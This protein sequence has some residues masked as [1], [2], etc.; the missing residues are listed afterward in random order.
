MKATELLHAGRLSDALAA[1]LDDVKKRPTD[2]AARF[3]LAE[4]LSLAGQWERADKQLETIANQAPDALLGVSLFRQLLRGELARHECFT[5]GRA[6]EL[7]TEPTAAIKLHLQALVELRAGNEALAAQLLN[8][9]DEARPAVAGELDGT[10]FDTLR[11]LDDLT[12][13]FF[14]V[15]TSTG[16]YFWI[17]VESVEY[18]ELRQP[19]R[20]RDLVWQRAHMT[21]TNGPDG[22]VFLPAIYAATYTQTDESFQ[23]GRGTDW[24]GGD[25][26]PVRGIG[27][28]TY[29]VGDR[30]V[31]IREL[32][33]LTFQTLVN[34]E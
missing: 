15:I 10:P 25:A 2:T 11:D 19:Q 5:Q 9:A 12:A 22:E 29:L 34:A 30:D 4:L 26:S 3:Y 6:P 13:S 14:E 8:A 20:T 1:A 32:T 23:L 28:R 17:P 16:K 18:L 21:V 27:Q 33:T 31:T 7:V 24:L